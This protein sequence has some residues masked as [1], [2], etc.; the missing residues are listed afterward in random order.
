MKKTVSVIVL[1]A[2]IVG[3]LSGI[4]VLASDDTTNPVFMPQEVTLD[5]KIDI[6]KNVSENFDRERCFYDLST[7]DPE[8]VEVGS[9]AARRRLL[10]LDESVFTDLP[11]EE[12]FRAVME[13]P[14]I[15]DLMAFNTPEL[16][17]EGLSGHCTALK[18]F[19]SR[20]DA[21]QVLQAAMSDVEGLTAKVETTTLTKT[22][23]NA[24][25]NVLD[26][27]F[28]F[29]EQ[30]AFSLG[31]RVLPM[32]MLYNEDI[33]TP[34]GTNVRDC[35]RNNEYSESMLLNLD[36]QFTAEFPQ[37]TLYMHST[38]LYNCHG[39]AWHLA[40]RMRNSTLSFSEKQVWMLNP[41]VYM[42]DGS[43]SRVTRVNQASHVFYYN[44]NH[45]AL[46][47]DAV[48]NSMGNA[49]LISKWSHGPVMI[50]RVGDCPYSGAVS[51]WA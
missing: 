41:S 10:H 43:Y 6:V 29:R 35:L 39:Y 25:L 27:Y 44:T 28:V 7:E 32:N 23:F 46:V 16:A 22:L 9:T 45:S 49:W 11:T 30:P 37:A 13:Y 36:R 5:R 40:E 14:F 21:W 47:H 48:G 12:V 20:P 24:Y 42:N 18:V 15:N 1:L 8:W 19:V 50:H 26:Q 31:A 33:Y 4:S 51:L 34:N 38:N 17:V 2:L 3:I